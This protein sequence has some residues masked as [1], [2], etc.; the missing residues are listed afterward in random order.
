M[1]FAHSPGG[2]SRCP[3]RPLRAADR[4]SSATIGS[5]PLQARRRGVPQ[6]V[7]GEAERLAQAAHTC[8]DADARAL[9][10]HRPARAATPRRRATSAGAARR[11]QGRQRLFH[12]VGRNLGSFTT[13]TPI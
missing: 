11:T 5:R 7:G 1:P 9:R 10:M 4:T 13:M 3:P 8:R 2:F 6:S 12:A